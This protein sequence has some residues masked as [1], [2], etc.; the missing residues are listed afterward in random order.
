MALIKYVPDELYA[1]IL[2]STET[3]NILRAIFNA[4]AWAQ[5]LLKLASTHVAQLD[6]PAKDREI[7]TLRTAHNYSA[8]HV[9]DL[10]E[11]AAVHHGLDA[12]EI[13]EL[14]QDFYDASVF[15]TKHKHLLEFID[16]LSFSSTNNPNKI[17]AL[18]A[19]Y[20]DQHIIEILVI[21]G[22]AYIVAKATVSLDM[23]PDQ[24]SKRR[25]D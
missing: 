18:K 25:P 7:V 19:Y 10:R 22:L 13:A 2:R 8:S 17:Q 12:V 6:L 20:N 9:A 15:D 24:S 16:M 3:A 21:H 1:S 14:R 23:E 5:A 4:P 11:A